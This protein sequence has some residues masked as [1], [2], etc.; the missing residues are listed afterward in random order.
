[1][2]RSNRR[3][4]YQHV[5]RVRVVCHRGTALLGPQTFFLL[6]SAGR[7]AT[8]LMTASVGGIQRKCPI[9]QRLTHPKIFVP[10][11]VKLAQPTR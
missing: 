2:E 11:G 7:Q 10:V 1:M 3:R 8:V 4:A 9:S 6:V 5:A